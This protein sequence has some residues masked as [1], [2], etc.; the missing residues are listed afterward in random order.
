[1]RVVHLLAAHG[2]ASTLHRSPLPPPHPIPHQPSRM[3]GGR[4]NRRRDGSDAPTIHL[5]NRY[6]STAPDFAALAVLYPSFRPF[7]SVSQRGRA[8]IDFT[9]FHATRELTRVL[10]LHDHGVNWLVSLTPTPP[11]PLPSNTKVVFVAS[12]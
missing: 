2:P 10:L 11:P 1:V 12:S 4:K 8:S 6:A 9:D 3:G 5:R 7:V